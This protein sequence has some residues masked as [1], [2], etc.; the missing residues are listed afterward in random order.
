MAKR[1]PIDNTPPQVREFLKQLDV[2]KGEYVLEIE[3]KPV[4]GVV[5]PRQVEQIAQRREEILSL[6]R[7]SWERNR[8]VP[9][10]EVNQAVSEAIQEVR[11]KRTS[12]SS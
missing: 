6:L 3:G 4:A 8:A 9:E 10:E 1:L 12:G 2:E 7:R 5:S 11:Q